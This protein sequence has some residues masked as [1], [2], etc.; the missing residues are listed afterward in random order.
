M[1]YYDYAV[2]AKK[3]PPQHGW[4]ATVP[5]AHEGSWLFIYN[6]ETMEKRLVHIPFGSV[7][8]TRSDVYHGGCLV[9]AGNCRMQISFLVNHMAD[10]YRKI[11][12]V[13]QYICLNNGIYNPD[14]FNICSE[15]SPVNQ[16]TTQDLTSKV[17]E[18]EDNYIF[19]SYMWL[20]VG[21]AHGN[22]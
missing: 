17:Q 14:H 9:N 12:N 6:D 16:E 11:G 3:E 19:D 18:I 13:S 5:L 22:T 8:T 21:K 1:P 2:P 15:L 4:I 20:S 10:Y 7:F